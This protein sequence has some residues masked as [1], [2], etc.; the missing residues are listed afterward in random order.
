M[1]KKIITEEV[2][3][4]YVHALEPSED[5]DGNMK[6]SVVALIPKDDKVTLKRLRDAIK[7][8]LTES[9]GEKLG[10]KP[11]LPVRDGDEEKPDNPEYENMYF[12]TAKSTTKPQV[13][14]K[15]GH[16]VLTAEGIYSG[17]YARL[18]INLYTFE[19][20]KGSKGVAVGLNN[21]MVTGAGERL[22]GGSTAME[23]FGEF[24]D[25]TD[26]FDEADDMGEGDDDLGF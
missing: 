8:V 16:P 21:I 7:E 9:W 4:S 22:S 3:L 20:K 2:R 18:S 24:L 26:D 5:L 17:C 14:N 11:K 1:A 12:I 6:Y 19:I 23:D 10:F 13:L 15:K 25:V